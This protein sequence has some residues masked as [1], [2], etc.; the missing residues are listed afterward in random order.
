MLFSASASAT[1]LGRRGVTTP[2]VAG[3]LLVSMLGMA[4]ILDRLWLEAAR[5]E[6]NTAA[7]ASALAAAR[8][9]ASDLRLQEDVDPAELED[10]AV[11]AA[12]MTAVQNF[13]AGQAVLINEAD[14]TFTTQ[15]S[16]TPTDELSLAAESQLPPDRVVVMAHRTRFRGNPVALFISE[17]T[18]QPWGDAVGRGAARLDGQVSGVRPV[19]GAYVPAVPLA[20]WERDPA[21]ERKDTWHAAIELRG[22]SDRYGFDPSSHRITDEPDGIPE[23]TLTTQAR[24]GT[25]RLSNVQLVDLGSN[26]EDVKLRRQFVRGWSAEDLAAW[27]GELRVPG[28]TTT[29]TTTTATTGETSLRGLPIL[30]ANDQ[31]DLES[32]LG[33][34]RIALLYS[35]ATLTQD[36]RVYDVAC[37]RLVAI[38]VLSVSPQSDGSCQIVVQPTVLATRSALCETTADAVAQDDP[39]EQV[40][41][42]ENQTPNPSQK[43]RPQRQTSYIYRLELT[44]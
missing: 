24:R 33:T 16:E 39:L 32:L 21:G 11:Q 8:E 44:R 36:P 25:N 37:V 30:E 28:T 3:V 2:V 15:G 35:T 17:L 9:L 13:A 26:F 38:R 6:L 43:H 42:V 18:G 14:V 12:L 1:L 22:G 7:E 20:I 10:Q 29:G 23:L 19:A 40:A 4:L 5:L 31:D 27:G 41:T 34:P